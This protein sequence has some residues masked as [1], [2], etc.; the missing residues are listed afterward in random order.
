MCDCNGGGYF[1]AAARSC[2]SGVLVVSCNACTVCISCSSRR[3]TWRWRWGSGT[4]R[5]AGDT[6][7]RQKWDSVAPGTPATPA[8]PA[9]CQ[10]SLLRWNTCSSG[11]CAWILAVMLRASG[12]STLRLAATLLLLAVDMVLQKV[13]AL[14]IQR[15]AIVPSLIVSSHARAC[16]GIPL[17]THG[18]LWFCGFVSPARARRGE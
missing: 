3:Y 12:P 16:A 15:W 18:F 5:K 9:C 1:L 7:S 8:C 14:L 17:Y 10:V 4:C 6:N 11:N 13:V 2:S